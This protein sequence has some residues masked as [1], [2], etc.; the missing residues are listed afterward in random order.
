MKRVPG[1]AFV[2]DDVPLLERSLVGDDVAGVHG[3]EDTLKQVFAARVWWSPSFSLGR[4]DRQLRQ[5]STPSLGLG[6]TS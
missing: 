1:I 5:C 4:N 6:R 2:K 3:R